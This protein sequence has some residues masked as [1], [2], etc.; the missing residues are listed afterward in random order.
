MP[1]PLMHR[2][3]FLEIP[4]LYETANNINH[5]IILTIKFIN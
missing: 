5:Y 2:D 3:M 1:S 4:R